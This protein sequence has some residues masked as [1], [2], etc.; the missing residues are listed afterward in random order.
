MYLNE[1][2]AVIGPTYYK[3]NQEVTS[4]NLDFSHLLARFEHILL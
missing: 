4:E 2:V 1:I 3:G